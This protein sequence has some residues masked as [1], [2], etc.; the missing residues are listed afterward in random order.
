[1]TPLHS[2]PNTFEVLKRKRTGSD[3]TE[4]KFAISATKWPKIT[5]SV[6]RSLPANRHITHAVQISLTPLSNPAKI[7]D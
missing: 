7:N 1:M 2:N 4:E 3:T 6:A 5:L